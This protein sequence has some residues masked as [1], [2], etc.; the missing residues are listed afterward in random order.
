MPESFDVPVTTSDQNK[1]Q[2]WQHFLSAE[3]IYLLN[4]GYWRSVFE[5]Q[6]D[7]TEGGLCALLEF[8]PDLKKKIKIVQIL[9]SNL[10]SHIK[11]FDDLIIVISHLSQHGGAEAAILDILDT[12]NHFVF[13]LDRSNLG[14]EQIEKI[15]VLFLALPSKVIFA[16]LQFIPRTRL[17]DWI[18]TSHALAFH[19]DCLTKTQ[20]C[21]L[22]ESLPCEF[23]ENISLQFS[24]ITLICEA[25]FDEPQDQSGNPYAIL[26]KKIVAILPKISASSVGEDDASTLLDVIQSLQCTELQITSVLELMKDQLPILIQSTEDLCLWLSYLKKP[27]DLICILTSLLKN[28][29]A[30]NIF[31]S[32]RDLHDILEALWNKGDYKDESS[33][34][35]TPILAKEPARVVEIVELWS[36]SHWQPEKLPMIC[37]MLAKVLEACPDAIHDRLFLSEL[38]EALKIYWNRAWTAVVN[39]K[40]DAIIT[41]DEL[42]SILT[43]V[44]ESTRTIIL[45]RLIDTH[46][47]N[48]LVKKTADLYEVLSRTSVDQLGSLV[49]AC[50]DF[51]KGQTRSHLFHLIRRGPSLAPRDRKER[52][53]ILRMLTAPPSSQAGLFSRNPSKRNLASSQGSS[54]GNRLR[55]SLR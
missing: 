11:S 37:F 16:M 53:K 35:L 55:F 15:H 3:T 40:V 29:N 51:F 28:V 33:G 9:A 50:P 6:I 5:W 38:L 52:I 42:V 2:A 27:G 1:N 26:F 36:E 31:S 44:S 17:G 46:Q 34:F 8:V 19:L 21:W 49:K 32:G 10:S 12:S 43:D 41:C 45:S 20:Q 25:L 23:F 48:T 14:E 4:E 18:Q 39:Q 24:D 13:E 54:D 22:L 7:Q 47:I 30:P